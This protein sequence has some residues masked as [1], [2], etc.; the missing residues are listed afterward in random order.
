MERLV[1]LQEIE[2][3]R[4]GGPEGAGEAVDLEEE[5]EPV[6]GAEGLVRLAEE[7]LVAGLEGDTLARGPGAFFD[8]VGQ[9]ERAD[10]RGCARRRDHERPG[11]TGELL[12]QDVLE[13]DVEVV[14]AGDQGKDVLD[15]QGL[16]LEVLELPGRQAEGE[17]LVELVDRP[18]G[19]V[20]DPAV[21]LEA[22]L[23]FSADLL[24][25]DPGRLDRVMDEALALVVADDLGLDVAGHIVRRVLD[26]DEILVLQDGVGVIVLD[27]LRGQGEDRGHQA[28]GSERTEAG[29]RALV[30]KQAQGLAGQVRLQVL[31]SHVGGLVLRQ[32]APR[33]RGDVLVGRQRVG[34]EAL[35]PVGR[36]RVEDVV[37]GPVALE[38][39]DVEARRQAEVR[40]ADVEP[41]LDRIDAVDV[42]VGLD[43]VGRAEEDVDAAAVGLP[44]RQRGRPAEGRVG[45]VQAA[46]VLLLELVLGRPG[47]RVPVLPEGLD[48]DVPLAVRLELQIDVPFVAGDDIGDLFVEPRLVALGQARLRLPGQG[49]RQGQRDDEESGGERSAHRETSLLTLAD[50]GEFGNRPDPPKRKS[51]EGVGPPGSR[52]W[53]AL[54][55]ELVQEAQSEGAGRDDA[56]DLAVLPLIVHGGRREGIEQVEHVEDDVDRPVLGDVD[57][58][59]DAEVEEHLGGEVIGLGHADDRADAAADD[60]AGS[61]APLRAERV[62]LELPGR[63]AGVQAEAGA[64]IDLDDGDGVGPGQLEL[65][66]GR[67]RQRAGHVVDGVVQRAHPVVVGHHRPF[68]VH[69]LGIDPVGHAIRRGEQ[70]GAQHLPAV[71]IPFVEDEL[72]GIEFALGL[73]PVELGHVFGPEI[74]VAVD[75]GDVVVVGLAI[76][77]VVEP[78]DAVELDGIALEVLEGDALVRPVVAGAVA[79]R[80]R[81]VAQD[82]DVGE[83]VP[84]ALVDVRGADGEILDDFPFEADRD[85]VGVLVLEAG[86]GIQ[87]PGEAVRRLFG[88]TRVWREAVDDPRGIARFDRVDEAVLVGV[89]L[90]PRNAVEFPGAGDERGIGAV[91]AEVLDGDRHVV[92]AVAEPGDGLGVL[93]QLVGQAEAGRPSLEV[94]DV[95]AALPGADDGRIGDVRGI[96]QGGVFGALAVLGRHIVVAEAQVD[97]QPPGRVPLVVDEEGQGVGGADRQE[98]VDRVMQVVE[99]QAGV[100]VPALHVVD[101]LGPAVG[102]EEVGV[103]LEVAA[104]GVAAALGELGP[105]LDVVLAEEVLGVVGHVDLDR[106]PVGVPALDVGEGPVDAVLGP[107]P[108]VDVAGVV[109]GI[110]GNVRRVVGPEA[111]VLG[112]EDGG[113]G[114]QEL[115]LGGD[116]VVH[117]GDAVGHARVPLGLAAPAAAA[118]VAVLVMVRDPGPV[119]GERLGGDLQV[120]VAG[121]ARDRDAPAGPVG[122]GIVIV[123]TAV[124]P[125]LVLDDGSAEGGVQLVVVGGGAA[126]EV[127][128]RRIRRADPHEVRPIG[129]RIGGLV[130]RPPI[131]RLEEDAGVAVELV[132]P[133]LRQDVDGRAREIAV[134]GLGAEGDDADLLDGVVVDL[135]EGAEGR[136][137]G[138]RG[139]DAVDQEDVLVGRAAVG[140]RAGQPAGVAAVVEHARRRQ[141]EVI[142]RVPARGQPADHLAFELGIDGRALRVDDRAGRQDRDLLFDRAG[143]HRQIDL[144]AAAGRDADLLLEGRLEARQRRRDLVDADREV[145]EDVGALGGGDRRALPGDQGRAGDL[146]GHSRQRIPRRLGDR[147]RQLAVHDGLGA[148]GVHVEESEADREGQ[149]DQQDSFRHVLSFSCLSVH[150]HFPAPPGRSPGGNGPGLGCV[151]SRPLFT[152]RRI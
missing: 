63:A 119:F 128:G 140:G 74:L 45:V 95:V 15:G 54:R 122:L 22:D 37:A 34:D 103:V 69:V 115:P 98:G 16:G 64:E 100:A 141:R 133:R 150:S 76:A 32:G 11:R 79:G 118:V 58:L 127:V 2:A 77:V 5:D 143:L 139:V 17:V 70:E 71:G 33:G 28:F 138:V 146:D 136:A 56:A 46:V 152:S 6:A 80:R 24:G 67:E 52:A 59:L 148:N 30:G 83:H 44:A 66:L 145:Q 25:G 132:A 109:R 86:S 110:A 51:P 144:E 92:P 134:L 50:S 65:E 108:P 14:A 125:D 72:E 93:G 112:R 105:E 126:V 26:L 89:G 62:V 123:E 13:K 48:E 87:P 61:A 75:P 68:E 91:A 101:V 73:D 124:E 149:R 82:R 3:D 47:Q 19:G 39:D 23:V 31:E 147:A 42:A 129:F 113:A 41:D 78:L 8:A 43:V 85:L 88:P 137:A 53:R 106:L 36:R 107:L 114:G 10:R 131:D 94:E 20:R 142:E 40:I 84:R 57:G 27:L 97:G 135:D 9:Q 1:L 117:A 12:G 121:P 116:G 90:G 99:D 18:A 104:H 111:Q 7:L 38:E 130:A 60:T 4:A 55:L 29:R 81:I 35:G 120:P 102:V 49:G 96:F 21:Q 151:R